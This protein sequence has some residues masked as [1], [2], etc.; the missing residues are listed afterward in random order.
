MK[1]VRCAYTLGKLAKQAADTAV[2]TTKG[3]PARQ[4]ERAIDEMRNLLDSA[5]DLLGSARRRDTDT[6]TTQDAPKTLW[7]GALHRDDQDLLARMVHELPPGY[8][9]AFEGEDL[10][11]ANDAGWYHW[12]GGA[13]GSP[14]H[15]A[16]HGVLGRNRNHSHTYAVPK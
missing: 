1:R 14:R 8:R 10:A 2:K 13:W 15:N 9:L 6:S 3:A 12:H 5:E 16:T 11:A 4:I 7:I